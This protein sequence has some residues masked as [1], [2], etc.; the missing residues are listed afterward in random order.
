[1]KIPSLANIETRG[2]VILLLALI[3]AVLGVS[4][5]IVYWT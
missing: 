4:V 3:I 2:C 1:V 5:A